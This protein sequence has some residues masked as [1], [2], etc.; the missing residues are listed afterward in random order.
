VTN[1]S[2]RSILLVVLATA[3]LGAAAPGACF[4]PARPLSPSGLPAG[5][6]F[7]FKESIAT[8]PGGSVHAIWH[9]ELDGVSHVFYRRSLD[10]GE[11]WE[12][13]RVISP[14]STLAEHPAIAASAG[15]VYVAW[16]QQS[17][18][19][20]NIVYRRSSDGG[21]TF[22]PPHALTTND[23]SSH[24]SLAAHGSH[25]QAVWGNTASGFAEIYARSSNDFATSF[26][27]EVRLSDEPYESWVP[28][29]D[30]FGDVAVAA[31]VDYRDA[32]EEEYVRVSTDRGATWQPA[33]RVTHD[34]ADSWAPSVIVRGDVIFLAW[35]DRRVAGLMDSQ[36]EAVLDV[37]MALVGLPP[38][39]AP[40]RDPAVYYLPHF[41]ERI[42]AKRNAIAAAAPAWVAAGGN[43]AQLEALLREHEARLLAWTKGWGIFLARSPD[44]GHTWEPARLVSAPGGPAVR[45]AIDVVHAD[46]HLTWF[47]GRHGED[48]IYYRYSRDAGTTFGPEQRLTHSPGAARR[49]SLAAEGHRV[50]LLWMDDREG[51]PRIFTRRGHVWASQHPE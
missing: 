34:A 50:H 4:D 18:T 27:P 10:A 35:F 15:H 31:W 40:P 24:V 42:A 43:V 36:V 44:L 1:G 3:G 30:V 47:D 19:G 25:V 12:I 49:P 46:L 6:S 39:P 7:N 45:P 33:V 29:V 22:G 37:A 11:T 2:R 9:A 21:A 14:G 41:Q 17:P 51:E 13:P 32:N 16:H 28:N 8:L 5:L 48:E 26:T 38:H 23:R 20:L